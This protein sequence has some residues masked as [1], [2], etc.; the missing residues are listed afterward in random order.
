[1]PDYAED[2]LTTDELAALT[3]HPKATIYAL[4]S[5][6]DGPPRMKIGRRV[7]YRRGDVLAW[8]STRYVGPGPREAA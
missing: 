6:G 7:L 1:M 5:R 4:N 3:R 2:L 8:L